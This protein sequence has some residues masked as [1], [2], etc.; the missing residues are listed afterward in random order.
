MIGLLAE[1]GPYA[2]RLTLRANDSPL[3]LSCFS[4]G[5]GCKPWNVQVSQCSSP[6]EAPL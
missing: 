6:D 5:K 4:K 1:L 3:K 2:L